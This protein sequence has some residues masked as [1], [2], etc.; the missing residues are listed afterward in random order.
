MILTLGQSGGSVGPRL[1]EGLTL[2]GVGMGVVF[3][4]LL[5]LW[6]MIIIVDRLT[7]SATPQPED[8]RGGPG[9][10][11][12][13]GDH[14]P[15]LIAVLTAAATAA[16]GRRVQLREAYFVGEADHTW[17]KEGR[18]QVMRSHHPHRR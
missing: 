11:P 10:E 5:L 13:G 2:M 1:S 3:A 17:A 7:G 12:G 6:V 18:R 4:A 15:Q 8:E 9:V 14:D 16:V